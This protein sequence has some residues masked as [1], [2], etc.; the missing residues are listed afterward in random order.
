MNQAPTG[1]QASPLDEQLYTYR[2]IRFLCKLW[3]FL[4]LLLISV[5]VF[6]CITTV[7]FGAFVPHGGLMS[8][9]VALTSLLIGV[10]VA[11]SVYKAIDRSARSP[12]PLVEEK[13]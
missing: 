7:A 10:P 5:P 6:F 9:F 12:K 2:L 1:E 8:P 3:I 4:S 11:L 13:S